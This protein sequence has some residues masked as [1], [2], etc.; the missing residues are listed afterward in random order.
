MRS[1][2]GTARKHLSYANVIATLA[3]FIA[4]GGVGYAAVKLPKNSVGSAQLKK[5]AVTLPK[6]SKS[7]KSSLA[8]ARGPAGTA[9]TAGKD[10]APGLTGAT[11]PTDA[12]RGFGYEPNLTSGQHVDLSGTGALPVGKFA[13]TAA[14]QLTNKVNNVQNIH[15]ELDESTT[16]GGSSISSGSSIVYGA[17]GATASISITGTFE[18]YAS[19]HTVTIYCSNDGTSGGGMTIETS[20]SVVKVGAIHDP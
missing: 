14:I 13:A 19:G 7:A 1:L 20:V 5:G 16:S 2:L 8:G 15:C 17:I 10:G 3:L 9:G 11:G 6:I 12:Y 18:T 4:L